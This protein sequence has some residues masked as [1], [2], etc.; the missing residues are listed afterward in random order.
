MPASSEW[1]DLG[2]FIEIK[3]RWPPTT[4]T[5]SAHQF[6]TDAFWK[7]ER[8]FYKKH[9]VFINFCIFSRF[10]KFLILQKASIEVEKTF[11]KKNFIH[12]A[13]YSKFATPTDFEKKSDLSGKNA[14]FQKKSSFR[15]YLRNLT[16]WATVYS[17]FAKIWWLKMFML[18]IWA[19]CPDNW[20]VNVKNA[21]LWMDDFAIIS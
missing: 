11:K 13:F 20:Q 9:S 4:G 12:Y 19:F 21:P 16:L 6:I 14:T 3:S 2:R 1:L 8:V 18:R 17:K 15:S 7:D 10:T 5:F